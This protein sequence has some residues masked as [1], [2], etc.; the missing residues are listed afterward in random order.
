[1]FDVIVDLKD[2]SSRLRDKH[3]NIRF[4]IDLFIDYLKKNHSSEIM[5]VDVKIVWNSIDIKVKPIDGLSKYDLS[6]TIKNG[7]DEALGFIFDLNKVS[8][9]VNRYY[10]CTFTIW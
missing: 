6:H 2:V 3:F 7:S 1:M 5:S 8:W 9:R 10:D 4:V